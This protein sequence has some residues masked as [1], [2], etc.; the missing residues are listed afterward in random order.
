VRFF[1]LIP[2]MLMFTGCALNPTGSNWAV[3]DFNKYDKNYAPFPTT[4]LKMGL[5]KE[6]IISLL[7]DN[8][9]LIEAGS[10]YEVLAYQQWKSVLGPDYQ[11]KTLYLKLENN[12]LTHWKITNDT[13]SIVPRSW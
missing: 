1:I 12:H 7:G 4:K 11:E 2:I 8:H 3:T 9:E 5:S 6:K 10:E 13:I